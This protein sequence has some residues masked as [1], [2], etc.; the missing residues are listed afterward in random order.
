[1]KHQQQTLLEP[2]GPEEQVLLYILQLVQK[3][4]FHILKLPF[5]AFLPMKDEPLALLIS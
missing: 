1:L 3:L 2:Q 4:E 5:V